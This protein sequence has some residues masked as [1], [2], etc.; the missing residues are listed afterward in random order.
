M[1]RALPPTLVD[2]VANADRM[3]ELLSELVVTPAVPAA[4]DEERL[5]TQ[6]LDRVRERTGI[7]FGAYKRPTIMRRLQRRMVATANPR[8]RDYVRYAQKHPE[9]FQRLSS[10]F[11]IKVTQFFRD[12]D[13]FDH[14]RSTLVPAADRGGAA[15]RPGAAHLVGRLRDRRGGVLAGDPRRRGAGHRSSGASPCGS[16]RPTSTRRRSR[17]RVAG[18]TRRPR[19]APCTLELL[20]AVLRAGRRPLRG[21]E[22]DPGDGRV[23]AARP[24]AAGAVPA[25]R[26]RAVPE[27]AHLLHGRAPGAGAP[28]VR[29]LAPRRRV[30]GARQG[31]VVDALRRALHPRPAAAQDLPPSRG[32][33][34]HP[35]SPDPRHDAAR[36]RAGR[37]A[38]GARVGVEP[39]AGARPAGAGPAAGRP[40][41]RPPAAAARRRRADRRA[42]RH[43][44]PQRDGPAPARDLRRPGWA[45]TSCTWP[46]SSRPT[47][48][49][50]PSPRPS[51]TR[52]PS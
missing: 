15:P 25:D 9:E 36:P 22:G 12:A 2:F 26:P 28:A 5:L 50:P 11:L 13:L 39:A 14:L 7:D 3:A 48:C 27:R 38:T 42:L 51:G 32:T 1:P 45:A 44:V 18:C 6:F 30:P 35:A 4:E 31:R 41:R 46:T 24:R 47:S 23:R 8:L 33:G 49:A 19:S 40:H 16:S 43:P 17:S 52:T 20:R 10:A 21:R 29:V 34:A 37:A